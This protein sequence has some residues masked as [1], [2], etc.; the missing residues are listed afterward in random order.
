ME[1]QKRVNSVILEHFNPDVELEP[2]MRAWE[3]GFDYLDRIELM[4]HLED[5]F[6]ITI[7]DTEAD[8]CESLSDIY[9]LVGR[10][11]DN[12]TAIKVPIDNLMETA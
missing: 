8:N 12:S 5:E 9:E 4:S 6:E 3:L 7:P 10:H 2:G 1:L 11:Y